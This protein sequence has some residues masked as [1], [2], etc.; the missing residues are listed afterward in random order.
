ML[1]PTFLENTSLIHYDE[2]H[3]SHITNLN[4]EHLKFNNYE[5]QVVWLNTYDLNCFDD[6]KIIVQENRLDEFLLKLLHN[7]D[8]ANK[9]IQLDREILLTMNVLMTHG[10]ELSAEHMVFIIGGQFIWS[11]QEKHGDYFDWIRER[12]HNNMGII[13]KRGVD[14]LLFLILESIIE[15]YA[16]TFAKYNVKSIEETSRSIENPSP[17][18]IVKIE[19]QKQAL[20]TIRRYSMALRDAITKLEKL[21][22]ENFQTHYFS[23]LKE[24][25][26]TLIFDTE[27][28]LAELESKMNFVF[29]M[30]SHRLNEV[31]KTLTIFSVIFIPLSFLA[32]LYGMN[33]KYI[34]ELQHEYG[35]FYLLGLMLLITCCSIWYFKRKGWF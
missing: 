29:S 25:I 35:Y 13:R 14:Y 2:H 9:L 3:K 5:D 10:N 27:F 30:Q 12:L 32:G 4:V 18:H 16:T 21:D 8:H 31:M 1:S 24:Q 22:F 6:S 23:E 26:I 11:Q 19:Q 34:P 17:D 20:N 28:E 15:N 33:F 7:E